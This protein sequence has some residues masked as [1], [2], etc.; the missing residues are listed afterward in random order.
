MSKSLMMISILIIII[1]IFDPTISIL[2]IMIATDLRY[3]TEV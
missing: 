2:I 1:S 3:A